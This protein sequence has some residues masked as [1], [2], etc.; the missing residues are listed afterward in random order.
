MCTSFSLLS[1]LFSIKSN[2]LNQDHYNGYLVVPVLYCGDIDKG[3]LERSKIPL[4]A[5]RISNDW[6]NVLGVRKTLHLGSVFAVW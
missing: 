5:R 6:T 1:L 2:K 3:T 4:K